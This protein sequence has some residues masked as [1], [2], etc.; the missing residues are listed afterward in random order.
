MGGV[1]FGFV[2]RSH[3]SEHNRQFAEQLLNM[4]LSF[5]LWLI[6]SHTQTH[7]GQAPALAAER[8]GSNELSSSNGSNEDSS[9]GQERHIVPVCCVCVLCDVCA[10]CDM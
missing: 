9:K 8:S 3:N 6:K 10:L 7:D 4:T 5:L 1:A 2:R